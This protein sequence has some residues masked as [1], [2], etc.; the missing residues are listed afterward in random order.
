M[1]ALASHRENRNESQQLNA[2]HWIKHDNH[3]TAGTGSWSEYWSCETMWLVRILAASVTHT[4]KKNEHAVKCVFIQSVKHQ[5]QPVIDLQTRVVLCLLCLCNSS[6]SKQSIHKLWFCVIF[7]FSQG[8]VLHFKLHPFKNK[9]WIISQYKLCQSRTKKRKSAE[10]LVW[11]WLR[12]DGPPCSGRCK[13]FRSRPSPA[14]CERCKKKKMHNNA[15]N[16]RTKDDVCM[17]YG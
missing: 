5:Q 8:F 13:R 3:V 10:M 4:L 14:V 16:P 2:N 12:E 17:G 9:R 15:I 7:D 6:G 11:L 1:R